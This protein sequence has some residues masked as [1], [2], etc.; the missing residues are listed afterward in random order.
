[1]FTL[2]QERLLLNGG[3]LRATPLLDQFRVAADAGFRAVSIWRRHLDPYLES[4]GTLDEVKAVLA[5]RGVAVREF[6]HVAEWIA[7]DAD[8]LGPKLDDADWIFA[9]ARE[10][11]CDLVLASTL[12]DRTLDFDRAVAN[13]R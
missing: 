12:G 2:L 7:L 8:R 3:T 13:V 11:D 10:L 1:M 9:T 6:D 4:G 5:R